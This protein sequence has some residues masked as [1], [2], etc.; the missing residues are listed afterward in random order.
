MIADLVFVP[1]GR[2]DPLAMGLKGF[3][4]N[5]AYLFARMPAIHCT[6]ARNRNKETIEAVPVTIGCGTLTVLRSDRQ[7]LR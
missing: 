2:I 7:A 5:Y 1:G 4:L 6:T 3:R